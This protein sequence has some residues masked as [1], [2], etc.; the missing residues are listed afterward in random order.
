[1]AAYIVGLSYLARRESTGGVT[2]YWPLIL[3][4]VPIGLV[5]VINTG[6]Q[7]RVAALM[8]LVPGLW[9]VRCLRTTFSTVERDIGKTVSGLL[10]GIVL[11]DLLAVA[12]V[13]YQLAMVFVLLFVAALLLQRLFPAT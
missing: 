5:F 9:I 8:S 3:L 13:P 6:G 11:V 12:D 7:L 2:S 10:A 1:M 4:A